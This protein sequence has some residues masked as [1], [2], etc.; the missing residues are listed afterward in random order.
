[1]RWPTSVT[2]TSA[3]TD[4]EPWSAHEEKISDKS[5]AQGGGAAAFES[6]RPPLSASTLRCI[7]EDFGFATMAPVHLGPG[8]PRVALD[9]RGRADNVVEPVAREV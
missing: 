7:R 6:V 1:M 5:M 4:K 3:R 8:A 2:A 9:R